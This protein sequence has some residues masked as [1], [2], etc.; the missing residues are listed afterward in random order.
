MLN[1]ENYME[2]F[3]STHKTLSY[4]FVSDYIDKVGVGNVVKLLLNNGIFLVYLLI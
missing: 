3:G 1:G 4:K 2:N